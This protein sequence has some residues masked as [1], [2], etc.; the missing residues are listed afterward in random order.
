MER[1]DY[2]TYDTGDDLYDTMDPTYEEEKS[3]KKEVKCFWKRIFE[4]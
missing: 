3:S 1:L 2:E 4:S